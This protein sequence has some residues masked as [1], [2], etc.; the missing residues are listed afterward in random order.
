[1]G[2]VQE[3]REEVSVRRIV[4]S[5]FVSLDGVVE[6]PRW[7]F[8][9]G[10]EE[11]ERFKL[12]ELA[13]S[14]ALLLGRMTYEGFAAAWPRMNDEE[15]FAD[16]MNGYP[17][18]VVSTTLE[19]PLEWNNSTLIK[20]D[21]VEQFTD[22]KRQDGKDIAVHGSATLVRTL[23]EHDLIDE[24]RLMVF[25]IVVGKG[26]RLFGEAEETKAMELVE[27]KPLG[28]NGILVLTYRPARTG[29]GVR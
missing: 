2:D 9:F 11:Q 20:G 6:D 27:A 3:P 17:K 25:L 5:E 18:Y 10:S 21:I 19:E 13:A 23:M 22:L 24:L 28:P 7:T 15:G 26:K 29:K 12:D 14:D 1:L 8:R 4:V 16:R